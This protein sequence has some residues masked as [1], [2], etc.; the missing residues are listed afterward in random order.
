MNNDDFILQIEKEFD[1]ILGAK[2]L[3]PGF[4]KYSFQKA[5]Q[6]IDFNLNETGI[7]VESI[8]EVNAVFGL[9]KKVEPRELNFDKPFLII[10][11]EKGSHLPY[12]LMW[13]GNHELMSRK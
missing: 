9:P 3:N 5:I 6:I 13:V 8:T 1:E 10:M 11:K 12:F 7:S 2:I 4:K